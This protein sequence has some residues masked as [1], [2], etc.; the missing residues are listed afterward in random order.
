MLGPRT[1]GTESESS[2]AAYR[3][4]FYGIWMIFW[5]KNHNF[6]FSLGRRIQIGEGIWNP[7]FVLFPPKSEPYFS[8]LY[9]LLLF[10]CKG[11]EFLKKKE[12]E[13]FGWEDLEVEI[14]RLKTL[15]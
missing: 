14:K 10:H 11:D 2:N 7:D 8:H 9:N 1:L 6:S 5:E 15:L 12:L 4:D 3:S 13:I